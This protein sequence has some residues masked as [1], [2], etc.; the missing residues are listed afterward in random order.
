MFN[1]GAFTLKNNLTY[2]E[3]DFLLPAQR[4][5]IAFSYITQKGLPFFREFI[6]R[7]VHLSPMTKSQISIFLGLSQREANEAISDLVERDELTLSDN[8]RL[9]LTDKANG[10]FID[11][12]ETPR[13]STVR[14]SGA[15]L[16]FDL[17][18]FTCL[19]RDT[20]GDKWRLGFQIKTENE[21]T[22]NSEFLAGKAFQKQFYDILQKGLL[23]QSIALESKD[24]PSVYTVNSVSKLRQLPV[25]LT[26]KLQMDSI[27]QCVEREDFEILHDSEYIQEQITLELSQLSRPNNLISI[28]QSMLEL[29]DKKTLKIFDTKTNNISL[30]YFDD[31]KKLEENRQYDRTSFLG[32]I[33]LEEN[34]SIFQKALAPI[35]LSLIESGD[36]SYIPNFRWV[37]P[38]DPFWGK[39]SRVANC[40]SDLISRS[41]TKS[42]KLYTPTIHLPI[43][44]KDDIKAAR[45]WKYEFEPYAEQIKGIIEGF[46][47]GNTEILLLEQKIAVVIYHASLPATFP[48]TVP[49]GFLT[50][51]PQYIEKIGK[52]VNR[53][54][55]DTANY[56]DTNDCGAIT[57]LAASDQQRP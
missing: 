42:K 29:E 13:L 54:L 9:T 27:G 38:S 14:D 48:C 30:Q 43:S 36:E 41:T 25:R 49:L 57:E 33:Y 18:T 53:Y 35:L 22:S 39:N 55:N 7:L 50:T 26:V 47:G 8:N 51:N 12:G 2:H 44:S 4:F 21:N 32:P 15:F 10:Y 16:T 3:V 40:L 56:K 37:A 20:T 52:V 28:F 19:D 31:L 5:N 6:L 24:Q 11:I 45:Q 23:P 34:W 46:L 17:V 1:N